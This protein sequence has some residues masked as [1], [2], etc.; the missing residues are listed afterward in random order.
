M[1][2]DFLLLYKVDRTFRMDRPHGTT[3]PIVG[4][5]RISLA[6]GPQIQLGSFAAK[7]ASVSAFFFSCLSQYHAT[8]TLIS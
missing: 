7:P 6:A 2:F 1:F 5:V 4:V 3:A 8:N